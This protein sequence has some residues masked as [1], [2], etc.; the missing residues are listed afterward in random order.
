MGLQEILAN[1]TTNNLNIVSYVQIVTNISKTLALFGSPMCSDKSNHAAF[2]GLGL[3][4]KVL[5]KLL[6]KM[7]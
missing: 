5:V 2:K 4:F 6:M 7:S 3:D 1:T